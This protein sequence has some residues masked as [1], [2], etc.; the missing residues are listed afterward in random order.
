MRRWRE[1]EQEGEEEKEKRRRGGRGGGDG[2]SSSCTGNNGSQTQ[3]QA[4]RLSGQ[5]IYSKGI[6]DHYWPWP[7][8]LSYRRNN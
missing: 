7:V 4:L 8:F 6:A 2:G 1:E 5:S 3:A